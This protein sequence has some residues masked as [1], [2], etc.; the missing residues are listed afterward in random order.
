MGTK[1]RNM[2]PLER[3]LKQRIKEDRRVIILP[4]EIEDNFKEL[5]H[6]ATVD[7]MHKVQ[8]GEANSKDL[9]SLLKLIEG[10]CKLE[11]LDLKRQEVQ[12]KEVTEDE[13]KKILEKLEAAHDSETQEG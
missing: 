11:S 8:S 2:V 13:I 9:N 1:S 3:D 12:D 6:Q 5:I 7:L 4:S 10:H